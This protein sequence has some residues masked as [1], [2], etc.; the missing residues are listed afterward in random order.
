MKRLLFILSAALL[1]PLLAIG[2]GWAFSGAIEWLTFFAEK[3]PI[4]FIGVM[5]ALLGGILGANVYEE[6]K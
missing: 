4:A 3:H 2:L 5:L 6:W 1:M